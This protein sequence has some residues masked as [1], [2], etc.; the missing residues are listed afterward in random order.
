VTGKNY[1]VLTGDIVRSGRL[2]P[3]ELETVRIRLVE[4]AGAVSGW[5]R[6]LAKGRP[7]F[8]RGDGWQWLLTDPAMALRAA[9]YLRAALLATGLADSR[10]AIGLGGIDQPASRRV[11][12]STGEAFVLSGRALDNM[13]LYA[14]MTVETPEATGPI[15][16]WLPVVAHL[17]DSLMV[18]WTRRQ[19]EMVCAAIHP[20]E[21]DQEKV[22][23][24]LRPVVSR[25]AVTKG[26]RGARWYVIREAL[27]R[28]EETPWED[29]LRRKSSGNQK[30]LLKSRQPKKVA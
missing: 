3:R 30:R 29:L 5:K 7:S 14:R 10:V 20:R 8:F 22:A 1:A 15:S 19:A 24:L 13:T 23:R 25:Q 27:H 28:F 26:L 21:P 2:R 9:V 4:A 11:A 16:G 6:G 17:C 12:L 18:Q